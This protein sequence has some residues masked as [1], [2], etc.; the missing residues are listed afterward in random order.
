MKATNGQEIKEGQIV[1]IN[2][3]PKYLELVKSVDGELVTETIFTGK[4]DWQGSTAGL[5][6]NHKYEIITE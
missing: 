4:D 6:I 5:S 2:N 3:D 1:R